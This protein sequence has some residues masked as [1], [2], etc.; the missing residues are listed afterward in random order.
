MRF[1]GIDPSTKTGFVALDERGRVLVAKEIE[2]IGDK[3]PRR[4]LTM[5]DEIML[6]VQRDD[7]INIENFGFNS[8]QAVQMGGI[9]WGIRM[10]LYALRMPYTDVAP[11]SLKSFIGVTGWKGEKGRKERLA[12]KEKKQAVAEA[13][14]ARFNFEH[15]NNNIVDAYVL[16]RMA[17]EEWRKKQ[18]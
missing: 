10:R 5:I 3:D 6:H 7:V 4:M 17:L 1:V 11:A 15:P 16:S 9:G 8:Q 2:G 18:K 13:V 12:G 14:K